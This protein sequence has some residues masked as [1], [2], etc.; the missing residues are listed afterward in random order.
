MLCQRLGNI[1]L[2]EDTIY[3]LQAM[4]LGQ[5][6]HLPDSLRGL[7]QQ[8]GASHILALSGLHLGILFGL[9][10][11][12]LLRLLQY[13]WRYGVGFVGLSLMWGYALV[14]GFPVSLCRASLMMSLM[15]IAQMRL[16]GHD[17]WHTLGFSAFLLLL[18]SPA[19]LFDV[20]FQL[21]FSAVMGLLLYYRRLVAIGMPRSMWARW[22][23][24]AWLISLSAQM[25]VLP[26]LLHYFHRISLM[27][28]LFSPLYVSLA[29][30][31]IYEGVL[32]LLL[33]TLIG[34]LRPQLEGMVTIQH[35]L[36]TFAVQ[37]PG[38]EVAG[39]HFSWGCVVLL[40]VAGLAILPSLDALQKPRLDVPRYRWA[41]FFRTWPYLLSALVL[42]FSAIVYSL[43]S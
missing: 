18:L 32:L 36:M 5:R 38:N 20:G 43:S 34:I 26:L 14:V 1:G 7:Y 12:C 16:V 11:L 23:W 8:S 37:L 13:R 19:M 31:I 27:G 33:P 35:S 30:L 10:N 9:F 2:P 41:M 39:V 40:Y 42:I 3:L 28:L 21:S 29:T 17:T 25:G 4:L 22:L 24:K 6:A 15:V